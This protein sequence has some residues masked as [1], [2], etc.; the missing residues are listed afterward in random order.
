MK[1]IIAIALAFL[2][3][4]G[5]CQPE[6]VVMY[7]GNEGRETFYDVMEISDGTI[8][9]SGYADN[10]NWIDASITRIELAGGNDIHNEQGTNRYGFILHLSHD[11]QQILRVVHF[12]QGTVEDIRFMKTTSLPYAATGN[13]YISGNTS[14][15]Y[16]N[17]GGYF[18]ARLDNNFV[19]GVPTEV[20]WARNVWATAALQEY[21][22]WDVTSNGKTY[23]ISGEPHNYNWSAMYRLNEFGEREVVENWRTHWLA[24]GGEWR[25]TPASSYIDGINAIS[26]S[27]IALKIWGRCEL[28]SWTQD[29]FDLTMSDGNGGTRKGKWPLDVLFSTPCDPDNP[30]QDGPGYNNYGATSC[31]PVFGGTCISIDKRNNDV[32]LGMNF[33]S[34]AIFADGSTS[35]D[36]EPA[37]IG[38]DSTGILNW[39]SR[40]YHEITPAGDTVQ[41]IP[42]QYIDALAIDYHNNRLVVGARAHGNNTENLWEGNTVSANT[43]AFGFQNQFTGTFGN[44]HESW[45]GKLSLE[46]GVLMNSTYM[47]ELFEGTGSLGTTH[48]DPNLDGWPDPNTGWPDVNTTR[49][50]KNNMKVSSNGDVC[51]L[52]VGRR[53][54][55]TKNAYQKMVKPYNGGLSCWNNFVRVYDENFHVP[56]YSSLIVGQWD[57]LTQAGGD[58]TEM[59]G[60]YKTGHGVICVGRQKASESGV[61]LGNDIPTINATSWASQSPQNE[62]AILVYY[63]ADSLNNPDDDFI[64]IIENR[65]SEELSN[66]LLIYPNPSRIQESVR[67]SLGGEILTG[68]IYNIMTMNGK[69]IAYGVVKN[70]CVKTEGLE[71]GMYILCIEKNHGRYHGKIILQE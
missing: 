37:V 33:K 8:L 38:M 28:R 42:D 51:L 54:I 4:A 61:A 40:L 68:A 1:T 9:V 45:L 48:P 64:N 7:A 22:P 14:D 65:S 6:N 44:I 26:Y 2:N 16:D 47:A 70:S 12:P 18:I 19:N 35:P 50:A 62:T 56:L 30:T 43:S 67:L 31:C 29:D 49:I 5:I 69:I 23:Y 55:T 53:T 59:F 27:G 13:I 3:L 25:G 71:Q 46:S 21:H 52:G 20:L 34:T 58:N 41:S 39:W 36:F 15:T 32:F 24:A 10:L 66:R 57:T 63:S 17:D 11:L 60:L